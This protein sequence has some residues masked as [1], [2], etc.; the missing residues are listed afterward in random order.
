MIFKN[1]KRYRYPITCLN[2]TVTNR[3]K[4]GFCSHLCLLSPS[5]YTCACPEG[6]TISNGQTCDAPSETP[7]QPLPVCQC[8]NGAICEYVEGQPTCT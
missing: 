5:S 8:R 3:C 6:A 2:F 7:A 1:E 4:I